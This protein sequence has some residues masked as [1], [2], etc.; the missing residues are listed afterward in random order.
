MIAIILSFNS[1]KYDMKFYSDKKTPM[2]NKSLEVK[3]SSKA[4]IGDENEKLKG[5]ITNDRTGIVEE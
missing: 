5:F 4:Y 1:Y 3:I 2:L